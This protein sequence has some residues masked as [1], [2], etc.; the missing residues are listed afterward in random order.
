MTGI[1]KFSKYYYIVG[2]REDDNVI[3]KLPRINRFDT[4]EE[5]RAMF[6]ADYKDFVKHYGITKFKII[7]EEK[8][9]REHGTFDIKGKEIVV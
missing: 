2:I 6:V 4:I 3:I 5:G 9:I 8:I 7:S 1:S